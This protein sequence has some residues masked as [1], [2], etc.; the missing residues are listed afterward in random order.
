M[1]RKLARRSKP[2]I[3]HAFMLGVK[4]RFTA[5]MNAMRSTSLNIHPDAYYVARWEWQTGWRLLS[6]KGCAYW[7]EANRM[8]NRIGGQLIK[9]STLIKQSTR[10]HQTS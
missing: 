8:R 1:K 10:V 2:K 4:K 7:K 9:G 6:P 3:G 5:Y